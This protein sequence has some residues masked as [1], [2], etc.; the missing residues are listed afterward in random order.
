MADG[1]GFTVGRGDG[2]FSGEHTPT[3][4]RRPWLSQGAAAAVCAGA[5]AIRHNT[6]GSAT[7]A[8]GTFRRVIAS[9]LPK[10][11]SSPAAKIT[12]A[13]AYPE[14]VA[15]CIVTISELGGVRPARRV[16]GWPLAFPGPSSA[17]GDGSLYG[18]TTAATVL[19][20]GGY[21]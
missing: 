4:P 14:S 20:G 16:V 9:T 1:A 15:G 5:S 13:P 7:A 19:K 17:S 12:G 18:R 8:A 6:K 21:G 10:L 2:E 11:S 3:T